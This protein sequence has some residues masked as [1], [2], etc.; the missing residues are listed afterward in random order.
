MRN[1]LLLG[2]SILMV[3]FVS[4]AP[5][6]ARTEHAGAHGFDGH[7]VLRSPHPGMRAPFR[8]PHGSVRQ[9]FFAWGVGVG[10]MDPQ[11]IVVV[12]QLVEPLREPLSAVAPIPDPK[13][14][15]PPM[16][17]PPSPAGS[18]TVIVQRGSKIEVVSF[19]TAR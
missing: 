5:V 12:P 19:P 10:W 7:G 13:F 14:M 16:P 3:A 9:P 18:H 2:L 8:G 6:H 15:F 4:T 17:N 11:V 1:A